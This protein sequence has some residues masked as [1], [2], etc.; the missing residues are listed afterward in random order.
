M[1]ADFTGPPTWL[2]EWEPGEELSAAAR[3]AD[4]RVARPEGAGSSAPQ[5]GLM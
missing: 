4:Q 1:L 3:A 5:Q 2:G